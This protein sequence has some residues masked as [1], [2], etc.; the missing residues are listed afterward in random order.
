MA[1]CRRQRDAECDGKAARSGYRYE[2][3]TKGGR[4][5]DVRRRAARVEGAKEAWQESGDAMSGAK[6]GAGQKERGNTWATRARR[7][8]TEGT[9]A[10]AE[11]PEGVGLWER[12]AHLL[13]YRRGQDTGLFVQGVQ[14]AGRGGLRRHTHAASEQ[15][16]GVV[17]RSTSERR[18]CVCKA[19]G[20][21]HTEGA[22]GAEQRA[23][24]GEV[25][26]VVG[27]AEPW[28]RGC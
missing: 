2:T 14:D 9:G 21:T 27:G 16:T 13:I 5:T 20:G 6:E 15:A 17:H 18:L 8:Q 1:R 11:A 3:D 12:P 19:S 28:H 4:R 25:V 7:S 24:R 26:W 10:A 22:L 23:R